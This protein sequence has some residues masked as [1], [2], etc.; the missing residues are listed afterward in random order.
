MKIKVV[1][2]GPIHQDEP[3]GVKD[4]GIWLETG[5]LVRDLSKAGYIYEIF[6]RCPFECDEEYLQVVRVDMP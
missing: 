3:E 4:R 2:N 5:K 6:P 1:C